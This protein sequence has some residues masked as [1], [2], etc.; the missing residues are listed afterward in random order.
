MFKTLKNSSTYSILDS[1]SV[2]SYFSYASFA[3]SSGASTYLQ[4]FCFSFRTTFNCNFVYKTHPYK[5]HG[6]INF[7]LELNDSNGPHV[8]VK[9]LSSIHNQIQCSVF[10]LAFFVRILSQF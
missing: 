6:I 10:Y 8:Q 3:V 4:C 2:K 5:S 7:T 9:Y 1:T